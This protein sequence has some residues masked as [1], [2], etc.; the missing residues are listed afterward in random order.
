MCL[1]LNSVHTL[2]CALLRRSMRTQARMDELALGPQWR[3]SRHLGQTLQVVFFCLSVCGGMPGVF[4]V[5]CVFLPFFSLIDR[6]FLLRCCRAPPRYDA[7]IVT[8][9]RDA[10]MYAVWLH[11]GFTAWMYG[12]PALP[13]YEYGVFCADTSPR[14]R[15]LSSRLCKSNCLIHAAPFCA[16]SLALLLRAHAGAAAA[17]GRAACCMQAD[18]G[19]TDEHADDTFR[20]ALAHGRLK[21][22]TSYNIANNPA[23]ATTLHGLLDDEDEELS[24]APS[25]GGCA[26]PPPLPRRPNANMRRGERLSRDA[27]GGVV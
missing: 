11:L 21:G 25:T 3:V 14:S 13:S 26:S 8:A 24:P 27:R 1:L 18:S 6:W 15:F 2:R 9:S 4:L 19:A 17:A 5:L 7:A 12:S 23:Y 16:L 22:L 20:E 10:L